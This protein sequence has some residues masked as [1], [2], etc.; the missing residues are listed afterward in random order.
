MRLEEF[1]SKRGEAIL[2]DGEK[3]QI[4]EQVRRA[5]YH[6]IAATSNRNARSNRS[7]RSNRNAAIDSRPVELSSP[8]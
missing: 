8:A 2:T 1:A 3:Q 4:D 5:A 6:I 7:A